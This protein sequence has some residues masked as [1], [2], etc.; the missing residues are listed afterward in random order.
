MDAWVNIV[1]KYIAL[2]ALVFVLPVQAAD[3]QAKDLV[4]NWLCRANYPSIEMTTIDTYQYFLDGTSKSRGV[5]VNSLGLSYIVDKIGQW[6]LDNGTLTEI[7]HT[8]KVERSHTE[9]AQA[10]LKRNAKFAQLEEELFKTF[11]E[12]GKTDADNTIKLNIA[13][14][15][16]PNRFTVRNDEM[17]VAGKCIRIPNEKK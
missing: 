3:I 2:L 17:D 1:K 15:A 7:V 14:E 16:E 9:K 12:N 13:W 11:S 10:V 6:A 8:E 5:I 4:G